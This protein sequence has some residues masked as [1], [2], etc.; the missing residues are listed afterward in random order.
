MSL[1]Y[2][3]SIPVMFSVATLFAVKCHQYF[4]REW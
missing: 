4:L 3:L 1:L 2:V